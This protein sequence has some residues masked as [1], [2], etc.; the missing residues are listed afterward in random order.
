MTP[1][2]FGLA[3]RIALLGASFFVEKILLNKFVDFD[4]AQAA[5]GFGA[6][7][8]EAQHWGFRFLVALAAAISLFAFVSGRQQLRNADQEVRLAPM[9]A[10]WLLLHAVLVACLIPLSYAL[11]REEVSR[12]PFGLIVMLWIGFAAAAG[13]CATIAMAPWRVWRHAAGALGNMWLFAGVAA[14]LSAS[15]MHLSQRL[16]GPTATLTFHLVRFLLERFIP[17]L[18]ADVATRVLRTDNFAVEVSEICSGLEGV[19]LILAFLGAWLFYFRREYIF[20]RAFLLVPLGVVGIFVLNVLRI[21]ALIVIGNL[22]YPD[23]AIYGFHSQAGWITFIGVACGLVLLSRRSRWL[24]RTAVHPDEAPAMHNPTAAYLM[25]MLA[26]LAAGM[27]SKALSGNFEYFYPLR[28]AMALWMFKRYR[29]KLRQLDWSFSW[30]GILVGVGIYGL[31][32]IAARFVAAPAPMPDALAAMPIALEIPWIGCRILGSVLLVPAAEELAYRGFLMRRL[33]K[34]DFESLPYRSVGWLSVIGSAA[35]F[36]M[37]HG[38]MWAPAVV[39]GLAYGLAAKYRGLG[40]SVA[41]HAAT[42]G[43]IAATVLF[44]QQWQLW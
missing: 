6:F 7:V 32:L 24:N 37:M 42:N 30:R 43:L 11:Y 16:W 41:A 29:W 15:V 36:G 12:L 17:N 34:A 31:W 40:E 25:P 21:A 33:S 26:I 28:V 2:R 14:L 18:D 5:E 23:V 13:W 20:P 10:S 4:R 44:A 1:S 39:A 35:L 19:G 3:S 22:G 9:R 27:A 8:R 38:F